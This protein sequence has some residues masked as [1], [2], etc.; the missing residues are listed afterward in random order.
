MDA[1]APGEGGHQRGF[2]DDAGEQGEGPEFGA[3]K[4]ASAE[5]E[6]T[7]QSDDP[8]DGRQRHQRGVAGLHDQSLEK[9]AKAGEKGEKDENAQY[10]LG[11]EGDVAG[12][13][14][15]TAEDKIADRGEGDGGEEERDQTRHQDNED[16]GAAQGAA[17]ADHGNGD[18]V[19]LVGG[20]SEQAVQSHGDG[21]GGQGSDEI[22]I[23]GQPGVD[24]GV[25]DAHHLHVEQQREEEEGDFS[26]GQGFSGHDAVPG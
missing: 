4:P 1:A 23:P 9:A 26:Q 14:E 25:G 7:E 19:V 8:N 2:D 12:D 16:D 6:K 11:V 5:G 18:G 17:A 24:D 21:K 15:Q 20:G 13:S 3:G 10:R 22:R